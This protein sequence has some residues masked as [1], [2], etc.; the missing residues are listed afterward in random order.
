M[1][2]VWKHTVAALPVGRDVEPL[3][4][5]ACAFFSDLCANKYVDI[6]ALAPL[7]DAPHQPPHALTA[8]SLHHLYSIVLS[9]NLECD[10]IQRTPEN[11]LPDGHQFEVVSGGKRLV[12]F[13]YFYR[14]LVLSTSEQVAQLAAEML[15]QVW[16]DYFLKKITFTACS[17]CRPASRWLSWPPRCSCRCAA[18]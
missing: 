13:D 4:D 16:F 9:V 18:S 8:T 5:C 17:C 14:V 10:L 7:I 2:I 12:G 11:V 1:Q 6:T 15:V 3:V